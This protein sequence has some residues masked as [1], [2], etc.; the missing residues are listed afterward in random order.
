MRVAII[1]TG[2]GVLPERKNNISGHLQIPLKTAELLIGKN[3]DVTLITTRQS[4]GLAVPDMLPVDA[5]L[6]YVSDGRRRGQFGKQN[7]KDGYVVNKM[8]SQLFQ[9]VMLIR[10][11]NYDVVHVFGFERMMKYGGFLKLVTGK[12]VVV[13]VLGQ[14]P[15]NGF[16]FLYNRV[17]MVMFL[18]ESIARKWENICKR[19]QV[20]YPGVVKKMQSKPG[21]SAIEHGRFRVL[22]WREASYMGGADLCVEAFDNIAP[23]FPNL[24]FDFAV[25]SNSSEVPGLDRLG[26]KHENVNIFRFPYP[27]DTT[28]EKLIDQSLVVVLPFRELSIEPQMAV[29]ET[30]SVGCPVICSKIG[31]LPELVAHGENGWLVESEDVSSLISIL[32]NKLDNIGVLEGMRQRIAINFNNKWNWSIYCKK[33]E[34]TYLRLQD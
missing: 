32:E 31:C 25:R 20:I 19:S 33:L 3:H 8:L 27:N 11:G 18:T 2:L 1:F 26:E 16:S 23:K 5:C 7:Y 17:D 30:L 21:G 13:T 6:E 22:F 9:T 10:K 12:S 14:K 34:N 24:S 28:L 29:V 15:R 4:D